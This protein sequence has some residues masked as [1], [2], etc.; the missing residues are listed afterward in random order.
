MDDVI[1]VARCEI[2]DRGHDWLKHV[3]LEILTVPMLDIADSGPATSKLSAF[4][5][6]FLEMAPAQK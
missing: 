5:G 4:H 6:A 1:D 2:L 3:L